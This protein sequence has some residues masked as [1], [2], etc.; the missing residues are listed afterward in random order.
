M[1]YRRGEPNDDELL[2]ELAEPRYGICTDS[3]KEICIPKGYVS[4]GASIPKI[5]WF[6]LSPFEDYAKCAIL[7]DYLCDLY[8]LGLGSRKEADDI[9]LE[10]MQEIGIKK[11]TTLTLYAF[12]RLYAIFRYNPISIKLF[13]KGRVEDYNEEFFKI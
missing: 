11:S 9:F 10:S 6:I 5:F 12:V 7:H 3:R 8:H 1:Y 2:E 4:D 13:G